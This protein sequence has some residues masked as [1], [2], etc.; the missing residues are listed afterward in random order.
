MLQVD[1]KKDGVRL[2]RTIVSMYRGYENKLESPE[3][4]ILRLEN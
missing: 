3:Q 2:A 1:N 4:I